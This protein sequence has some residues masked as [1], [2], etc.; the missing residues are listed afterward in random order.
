MT[1]TLCPLQ[2][3]SSL[4]AKPPSGHRSPGTPKGYVECGAGGHQLTQGTGRPGRRR[5]GPAGAGPHH[6][7][8][9][10]DTALGAGSPPRPHRPEVT[11]QR[12]PHTLGSL[13]LRGTPPE[14]Q[15]EASTSPGAQ[16]LPGQRS[17]RAALKVKTQFRFANLSRGISKCNP[18]LG[19][20]GA[21]NGVLFGWFLNVC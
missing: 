13:T 4:R 20:R 2:K 7:A 9:G 3:A 6:S 12:P 5:Q 14:K 19:E 1:A 15:G 16:S 18:H 11:A 17:R 21:G 8:A 10:V